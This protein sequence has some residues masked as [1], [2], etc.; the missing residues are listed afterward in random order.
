MDLPITAPAGPVAVS[1]CLLGHPCRFDGTSHL[2]E[3]VVAIGNT[4]Q[5]VPIC[6]E[7]LG[8]LPT[9]RP[10][11]EI[12]TD[13]R[14]SRRVVDVDGN[15]LTANYAQGAARALAIALDHECGCAILTEK[16]PSCGCG[17]V[18]DGTFSGKLIKGNGITA[19]LFLDADI[20]VWPSCDIL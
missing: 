11:A 17:K 2:N 12:V 20:P 9:P 10:P 14:G 7:A 6:P 15:D 3:K 13:E 8:G 5:L 18:F 4:R 16:S 19:Q 1:A